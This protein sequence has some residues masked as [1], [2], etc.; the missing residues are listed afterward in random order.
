MEVHEA[1]SQIAEIHRHVARTECYRGYR[2]LTMAMTGAV[3][4]LGACTQS[5]LVDG[6]VAYVRFWGVLAVFNL[7]LVAGEIGVDYWMR[8]SRREQRLAWRSVGQFLPSIAVGLVLT[9]AFMS[10]LGVA[11][12][13]GLWA[14]VFS[15]GVF[16]SRPYLPH[17]VGWVG[18]F[19]LVAGGAL[20]AGGPGGWSLAPWAMGATFAI[21]QLTLAMVLHWNLE[22]G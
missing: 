3:A 16:A 4:V 12:L 19:Y 6:P 7:V 20:L 22:R 10:T 15:L 5:Y 9:V 8:Q 14:L 21:G 17:G 2:P 1:L 11:M 18:L 13:P